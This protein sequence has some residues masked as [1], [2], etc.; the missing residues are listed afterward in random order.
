M[1][2]ACPHNQAFPPLTRQAG[3]GMIEVLVTLVILAIGLLGLAGLHLKANTA[4]M[5]SYQRTQALALVRDM[6][7]RL[8]AG[9]GY[10]ATPGTSDFAAFASTDGSRVFGTSDAESSQCGNPATPAQQDVC[11]WRQVLLGAT[12]TSAEGNIG[13]MIGARGCLITPAAPTPNAIADF[14]V[15]VVWQGMSPTADP[16]EGTPGALCASNV[17]FSDGTTAGSGY[18]RAASTRVLIPILGTPAPPAGG[19]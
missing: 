9:R 2:F 19:A 5:E 17:N 10:Q 16:A 4:E 13:A 15:V 8:L 18:R 11:A 3:F 7:T 14:Y 12:E 6:E 1:V